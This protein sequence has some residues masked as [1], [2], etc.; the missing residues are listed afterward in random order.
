MSKLLLCF[1][2]F[3]YINNIVIISSQTVEADFNVF[4]NNM[5]ISTYLQSGSFI[6][7]TLDLESNVT[8]I[9]DLLFG[10]YSPSRHTQV[11]HELIRAKNSDVSGD[12][13]KGNLQLILRKGYVDEKTTNITD[14]HY[15]KVNEGSIDISFEAT[16]G[17]SF[18]FANINYSPTHV[19]YQNNL[20]RAKKFTLIFNNSYEHGIIYFGE[21]PSHII[22]ENYYETKLNIL[23][24]NHLWNIKLKYYVINANTLNISYLNKHKAIFST[25]TNYIL[26]PKQY[27]D[28]IKRLYLNKYI[29]NKE[30]VISVGSIIKCDKIINENY[31]IFVIEN[32]KFELSGHELFYKVS[33]QYEFLIQQNQMN[34]MWIFGNFFLSNYIA[35]FNYDDQTVNLYSQ[36][37][38]YDDLNIIHQKQNDIKKQIYIYLMCLLFVCILYEMYL[39]LNHNK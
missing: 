9:S 11:G 30:C 22:Q 10:D 15:V 8:W 2:I 29:E 25:N 14:I 35:S 37:K 13:Y 1:F 6:Y 16:F 27:F 5:Y 3:I 7:Y 17:F 28:N 38:I 23:S 21:I 12:V 20:I 32:K 19:L 24:I 4:T 39:Y 26:A 31:I 34:D 18:Q 36:K 33:G